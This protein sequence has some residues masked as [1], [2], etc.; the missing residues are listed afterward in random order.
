[1][2]FVDQIKIWREDPV[3]FVRDQFDVEPDAWQIKGLKAFASNDREMIRISLQACAGPGKSCLLAWV[4]WNF[5]LCYGEVGNHPKAACVSITADN[6]KDGLWTEMSKWQQR[7]ELLQ[8]AFIWTQTRIYAK[9]HPET[10][11]MSARSFPQ[12]ANKET[13]GKTLSGLHSKYMLFLIDESGDIPIE[14]GKAAEQAVNE[15]LASGGFI[16]IMQAGNPISKDGLLYAAS[17]SKRW[18]VIRITG[19]P[20]DPERSPRIDKQSA[21]DQIDEYGRDDPWIISY[22]LG[23]FPNVA[24]NSLLTHLEVEQAMERTLLLT[25]YNYAQKRLGVDV[26]RGGMDSTVIF[27]RQ[28]LA[29]FK[30]ATMRK[31]NGPE[32]AARILMAKSKWGSEMEY[33]DDTGG[34][35]GSVIDS[36]QLSGQTPIG[37]HFASKATNPRYFN[38]RSEM[39]LEMAAWIRKGG[40]IPK[41]NKLKKEL[42]SVN[43]FIKNGKFMLESKDQIKKRLGFSP[44]IA[45]ALALTFAQVDMPASDKFGYL[46]NDNQQNFQSEYD[47]FKA[48]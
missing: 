8:H 21:Q 26:A 18:F 40:A 25:D 22:L 15:T 5:L 10:W 23:H 28:G 34:F 32:V 46:R 9:D 27:P 31:A 45:D 37:V 12:T 20:D 36:L 2:N 48:M 41:C 30:Y 33:I 47:P 35:G 19:D 13:I 16:K 14:I 38:K 7:S 4:G 11:Y 29:A 3:Q 6:L 44:D 1:L 24:I 39:W 17:I 43:Y 42:T